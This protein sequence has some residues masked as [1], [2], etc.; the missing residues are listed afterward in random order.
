MK[1]AIILALLLPFGSVAHANCGNNKN[2]GNGCGENIGPEG[3]QG[4]QG[5]PGVG[6]KGRDG[7]DGS[8]ASVNEHY[9]EFNLVADTAVRL[10]DGKHVQLQAFNVYAF[11]RHQG[12]DIFGDG[13][14]IMAGVRFVFKLGKSYEERLLEKQSKQ[15]KHL[16]TLINHL[17]K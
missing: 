17:S 7:K 15:I 5:L 14:N 6:E 4:P 16:E 1:I 3:P 2:V 13:R 9:R 8:N 12:D 10:Y 11:G